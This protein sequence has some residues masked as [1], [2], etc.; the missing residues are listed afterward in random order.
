MN[1]IGLFSIFIAA[2]LL[3]GTA[4]AADAPVGKFGK[5]RRVRVVTITQDGISKDF[6]EGSM[7]RLDQAA[8]FRPDLAVLPEVFHRGGAK[9]LPNQT[10]ELVSAWAKKNKCYV[11]AGFKHIAKGKKYNSAILF[12]RTGKIVGRFD[13]MYPTGGELKGGTTP[14]KIDP[15][16]FTTDFGKIGMQ[17]CYD[18]NWHDSWKRLKEKGAEIVIWPSAYPAD[19]QLSA[20]AWINKYYVVSSTMDRF[21]A[22]YDISGDKIAQTG[23][24]EQWAGAEISL[25]KRLFEIDNHV[26]TMRNIQAKYGK[27]VKVTWLHPEDWVTLESLDAKL[28]VDDLI[29]E[30][31]LTPKI[32]YHNQSTKA[33]EKARAKNKK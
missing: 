28:S 31:K 7:E 6:V 9:A 23:R 21:A 26:T 33:V 1:L 8:A 27:R 5:N 19:R 4:F 29:K 14:G 24:F 3:A 11:V 22:I 16:V 13:K 18:V 30:F 32:K 10:S 20:H 2:S 15:P 17:I 25:D 12:D